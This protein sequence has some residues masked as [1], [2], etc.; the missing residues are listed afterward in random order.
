MLILKKGVN[1]PLCYGLNSAEIDCKCLNKSC[2]HILIS[3]RLLKSYVTLRKL[4]NLP[5]TI[6]SGYRCPQHNLSA[7][8]ATLSRHMSG[9][10][11]DVS[12]KNILEVFD[13]EHLKDL[14]TF[15][16]FTFYK[17]YKTFVHLDVR[18]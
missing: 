9:E 11:I 15:S 13:E 14:I 1:V 8:G 7:G 17:F 2:Q 4:I 5:F 3:D 12:S 16:E 6:N 10:A 18:S